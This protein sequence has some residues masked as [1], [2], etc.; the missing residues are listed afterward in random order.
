MAY[1]YDMPAM[2][3]AL[4]GLI[5]RLAGEKANGWLQQ[6]ARRREEEPGTAHFNMVFTAIP[7]FV[8]KTVVEPAP[9][10]AEALQGIR[11]GFSPR[12]W[13]ADRLAR[14]WWLLHLDT[15]DSGA[16]LAQLESLFRSAEMNEQ[17]ALYGALPLLACGAELRPRAAEGIR[18]SMGPVFAAVAIDN[19]Y[20]AEYLDEAAWNQMVLKAFFMDQPVDRIIGLDHRANATLARMLSDYAHER[21]AAG[22]AVNPLLWRPVGPFL[23]EKTLADMQRLFAAPDSSS[24]EAAA[25]ACAASAYPAARELLDAHGDLAARIAGGA[26]D[27]EQLASGGS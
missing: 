14:S 1:A 12:G 6:Q 20:P 19:P 21:W 27:W 8:P 11:K 16:Y 17:V 2:R 18:T 10:E 5:A 23:D 3:A 15:T 25:L 9:A 26:L 22:R 24:R 4:E 7:R 13:T